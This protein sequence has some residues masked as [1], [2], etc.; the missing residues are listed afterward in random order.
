MVN[1]PHRSAKFPQVERKFPGAIGLVTLRRDGFVSLDAGGEGGTLVTKTFPFPGGRLHLNYHSPEHP[2]MVEWLDAAGSVI[3]RG[4]A[5][6]GDR[7]REPVEGLEEI[8]R[9]AEGTA[10]RLRV[11]LRG[12]QI[13]SWWL[14]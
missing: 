4:T 6:R 10:V 2:V 9:I 5:P 14:E 3:T 7:L 13:Y 8:G 11:S 12:G 1:G